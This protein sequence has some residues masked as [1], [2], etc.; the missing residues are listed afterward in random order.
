MIPCVFL[1]GEKG[2]AGNHDNLMECCGGF[3]V[4]SKDCNGQQYVR[5]TR[6]LCFR[7]FMQGSRSSTIES[8]IANTF[9]SVMDHAKPQKNKNHK[10]CVVSRKLPETRINRTAT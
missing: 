6:C 2:L 7:F 3:L 1:L 8:S 9:G 5:T 4:I 10:I